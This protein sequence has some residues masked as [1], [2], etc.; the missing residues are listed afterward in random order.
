MIA[1]KTAW[2]GLAAAGLALAATCVGSAR[3]DSLI[4]NLGKSLNGTTPSGS[5]PWL[6]ADF[7]STVGGTVTLTMTNNMP[8]A[9][10]TPQ[11]LFNVGPGVNP[12]NLSF[13]HVSGPNPTT[14][15]G[16]A[17]VGDASIKA[18]TFNVLFSWGTANNANRFSGGRTVVETITDA[19]DGITAASFKALST[20]SQ[21]GILSAAKVQGIP[22]A[23]GTASGTI[24]DFHAQ[25]VPEPSSLAL[26]IAGFLGAGAVV[27]R[28]RQRKTDKA[29]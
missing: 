19:A 13:T 8:S 16:G 18:G 9:E 1:R 23:G 7:E 25:S 22:A 12:A 21:G 4:L 15:V 5:P 29:S 28:Q 2:I 20:G 6:T 27:Y 14:A 3:A 10:F 24:V 17:T 26:G 11:W